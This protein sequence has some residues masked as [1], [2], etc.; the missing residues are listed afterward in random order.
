MNDKRVGDNM[1]GIPIIVLVNLSV[2]WT[3]AEVAAPIQSIGQE[4]ADSDMR[5]SDMKV[6]GGLKF[7]RHTPFLPGDYWQGKR[8]DFGPTQTNVTVMVNTTA[9]M[10]CPI[11]HVADSRV[12]LFIGKIFE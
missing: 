1:N 4:R 7:R 5:P 11:S 12:S 3:G 9:K 6:F 8:P 2:L 10:V